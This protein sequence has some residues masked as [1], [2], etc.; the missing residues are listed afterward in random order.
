MYQ[1]TPANNLND[2]S[3]CVSIFKSGENTV[4][5]QAYTQKWIELIQS[6]EKNK[7]EPVGSTEDKLFFA[8]CGI[9]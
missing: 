4:T 8:E 3:F 6:L 9:R 2:P 7:Y 5:S 1:G